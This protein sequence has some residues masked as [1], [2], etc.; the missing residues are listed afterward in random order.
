[1]D[2]RKHEEAWA[3]ASGYK[4]AKSFIKPQNLKHWAA[5]TNK[6]DGAKAKILTGI[7]TGHG[8]L[9]HHRHR[10]GLVDSPSCRFC[11]AKE[12]TTDHIICHCPARVERRNQFLGNP[13]PQSLNF[14][15]EGH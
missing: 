14:K 1:M 11:Q 15:T 6:L 4:T 12:E 10:I 3:R 2:G 7:I 5:L 8:M 9:R 13:F